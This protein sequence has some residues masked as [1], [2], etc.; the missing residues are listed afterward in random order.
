ME[1]KMTNRTSRKIDTELKV[2]IILEALLEHATV[3]DL[4]QR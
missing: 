3:A 1:R 2:R 4:A